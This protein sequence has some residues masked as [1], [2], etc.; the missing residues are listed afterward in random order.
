MKEIVA[1]IIQNTKKRSNLEYPLLLLSMKL[2]KNGKTIHGTNSA[3]VVIDMSRNELRIPA[4]EVV[5]KFEK[6]S[7]MF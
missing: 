2:V 5:V 4:Y 1:N 7:S 6:D 3:P